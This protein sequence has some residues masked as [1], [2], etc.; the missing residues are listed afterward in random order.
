MGASPIFV[1]LTDVGPQASA[2]WRTALALPVFWLWMRFEERKLTMRLPL[3]VSRPI[4]VVG[5]FFAGDLFFWHL[6]ILNTSVANA[7]F[8]AVTAPVFVVAAAFLLFGERA[9]S[10]TLAGL[11]LCL[12]GGAALV[13]QSYHI[14]PQ[15]LLGDFYGIVTAFFFGMYVLAVRAAR[16]IHGA[17]RLMFLSTGVTAG[18]LLIAAIAIPQTI[19]PQSLEGAA[20]LLAL[21]LV[22]QAGGQ[23]LLAIALGTLPAT[24]SSLVIFLEAVAAAA[25]GWLVLNEALT[26]IQALGGLLILL[27]IFVARPR[28]TLPAGA[29]P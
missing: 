17:G 28:A 13:G 10:R 21:A 22:S 14:D 8:F 15:R 24:F 16:S 2:F 23:G 29:A 18:L 4:F 9:G 19:L 25:L 20:A 5:V 1:R 27:G 12:A 7:T 11:A 26:L 6:A 3:R